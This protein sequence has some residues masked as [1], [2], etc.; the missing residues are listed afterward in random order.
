MIKNGILYVPREWTQ[1]WYSPDNG[2]VITN[3]VCCNKW[4]CQVWEDNIPMAPKLIKNKKGFS[5]CP[6]C[7][8][9]MIEE[10]LKDK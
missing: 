9:A 4:K 2:Q 5:F 1:Q 6:V 3:M 8:T 10:Y 7:D